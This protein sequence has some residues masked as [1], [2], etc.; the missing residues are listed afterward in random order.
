M[1]ATEHDL[2]ILRGLTKDFIDSVMS[3]GIH[4][5]MVGAVSALANSM[6]ASL[7]APTGASEPIE[8]AVA[9]LL[10]GAVPDKLNEKHGRDFFQGE[11]LE[12]HRAEVRGWNN[13]CDEVYRRAKEASD[14]FTPPGGYGG[15]VAGM[16]VSGAIE[17]SHPLERPASAGTDIQLSVQLFS[18]AFAVDV[19]RIDQGGERW[20][21]FITA[22]DL[23]RANSAWRGAAA[24]SVE[25][26]YADSFNVA[27]NEIDEHTEL[28]YGFFAGVEAARASAPS[29]LILQSIQRYGPNDW[30]AGADDEFGP[31]DG[32]PYVKIDD[33]RHILAVRE[34]GT[35]TKVNPSAEYR[36]QKCGEMS[37]RHPYRNCDEAVEPN[38]KR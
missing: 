30:A 36:C 32:G 28:W 14:S 17:G 15:G 20:C 22:F 26:L 23:I 24:I 10:R 3:S 25:D 18:D 34:Q 7:A 37:F 4:C 5:D 12:E 2:G 21:G 6:L 38:R 9:R 33:V 35:H 13:C 31:C 1:S 8:F 16:D 29:A 11:G 27:L 19:D